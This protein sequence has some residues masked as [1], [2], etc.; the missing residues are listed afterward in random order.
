MAFSY[1]SSISFGLVFIPVRLHNTVKSNDISFN[2]LDKR[3]N[4]RILYKKISASTGEEVNAEDIVKAYQYEKDRY[5]IIEDDD[6]EKIKTKRDKSI[7][8]ESFVDISEIDPIY[9]DKSYYVTPEG[10]EKAFAL[11]REAME[12]EGKIG[13][14]KT[15]LGS[16]ENLIAL[17]VSG[18]DMILNTMHFY[19]EIQKNPIK[20][21][22]AKVEEKELQLARMIIGSMAASFEP[23]NYQDEYNLRLRKAIEEKIR[24]EEITVADE[25]DLPNAAISLMEALQRTLQRGK[26]AQAGQ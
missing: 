9:Y 10:A 21:I 7:V 1:K 8:I 4:S 19:S 3:T 22:K 26:Q 24:G 18:G 2:M 17:R 15:V 16:K 5:V 23:E 25:G 13:I 20:E 11:L 12:G 6:F 14:A